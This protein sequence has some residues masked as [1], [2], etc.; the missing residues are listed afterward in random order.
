M[1]SL[2]FG[3][4]TAQMEWEG[5]KGNAEAVVDEQFLTGIET[6]Q[7]SYELN[8]QYFSYFGN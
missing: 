7:F 2:F 8:A 6:W 4:T 3:L 1:T 5:F